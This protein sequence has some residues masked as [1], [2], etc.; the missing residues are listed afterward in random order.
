MVEA[1]ATVPIACLVAN[2]NVAMGHQ[3]KAEFASIAIN[4]DHTWEAPWE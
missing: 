4:F 2:S 1:T 3:E